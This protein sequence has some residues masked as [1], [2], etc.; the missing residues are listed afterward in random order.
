MRFVRT[1][2]QKER[3]DQYLSQRQ[4]D[5]RRNSSNHPTNDTLNQFKGKAADSC[6]CCAI[7]LL[8]RWMST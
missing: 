4:K 2:E 5:E 3:A 8:A 6:N 1:G 7:W